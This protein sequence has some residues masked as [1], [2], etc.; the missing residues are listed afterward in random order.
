MMEATAMAATRIVV[1]MVA[2]VLKPELEKFQNGIL[3]I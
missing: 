3:L 1:N 2:V